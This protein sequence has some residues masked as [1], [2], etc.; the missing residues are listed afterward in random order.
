MERNFSFVNAGKKGLL[1]FALIAISWLSCAQ[2][3]NSVSWLNDNLIPLDSI[4]E[5]HPMF[6]SDQLR[7]LFS[8]RTVFGLGESTHGSGGIFSLKAELIKYLV[9]THGV[10]LIGMET[11]LALAQAVNE[12]LL[13]PE[14]D[15]SRLKNG[16]YFLYDTKEIWDLI[17]WLKAYN[18]A[19]PERKIK[20]FG[21]DVKSP[22]GALAKIS[23]TPE[24]RASADL[25]TL[26]KNL[27][28][29]YKDL[30]GSESAPSKKSLRQVKQLSDELHSKVSQL[31]VSD[32]IKHLASTL[33]Q[34]STFR[35]KEGA[36]STNYR[37]AFMFDNISWMQQKFSNEKIVVWAH[38]DH[39]QKRSL[40]GHRHTGSYLKEKYGDNY[41]AIAF[42]VG[43]G[44]YAAFIGGK[45]NQENILATAPQNSIEYYLGK[46]VSRSFLVPTYAKG[47]N[48]L[49]TDKMA[50]RNIG[51][52][53]PAKPEWQFSPNQ[54]VISMY[55]AIAYVHES[56]SPVRAESQK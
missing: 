20:F 48:V 7:Q 27:S 6:K 12:Y 37:D 17:K 42:T 13:S 53:V 51:W 15:T 16:V 2:S 1:G 18:L 45:F 46:A 28:E 3:Q 44:K 24:A 23:A 41:I 49:F 40:G 26:I 36:A 47:S 30:E 38:N 25:Q 8:G 19:H 43:T 14:A 33:V 55:D 9:K 10:T 52:I 35:T 32:E 29:C 56:G 34:L 50:I 54:P 21:F 11:D 39:I 22:W 5:S 31:P 4:T